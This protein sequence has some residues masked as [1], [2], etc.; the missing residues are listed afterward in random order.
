M[1]SNKAKKSKLSSK[2]LEPIRILPKLRKLQEDATFKFGESDNLKARPHQPFQASVQPE[3]HPS[4]ETEKTQKE[5]PESDLKT[6]T[7]NHASVEFISQ[8]QK[9][10]IC[11]DLLR[12]G[13][14]DS[15]H[16]FFA[17]IVAGEHLLRDKL[18]FVEKTLPEL[19]ELLMRAEDENSQGNFLQS[20][21]VYSDIAEKYVEAKVSVVARFF[22][23]RII[24]LLQDFQR[25]AKLESEVFFQ[26]FINAKL[27]LV[28]CYDLNT[29][30]AAALLILEEIYAKTN[31]NDDFKQQIALQLIQLY[32]KRGNEEERLGKYDSAVVFYQK[33]LSVCV[34]SGLQKEECSLVLIVANLYKKMG[35]ATR[36][37]ETIKIHHSKNV[38]LPRDFAVK[39]EISSLELLAKCFEKIHDLEEAENNY[40]NF[41]ELLRLN[42]EYKDAYA[43]KPSLKLGDIYWRKENY[44]EGLKYYLDYFEEGL[45]SKN[46]N[47]EII[48]K[49]RVTLSV[50]K[51]FDE[52]ESFMEYFQM[53]K[54]KVD[55]II[56]FKKH[57]RI[58]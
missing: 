30:S 14:L 15:F 36:A 31:S 51:G 2:K 28:K 48:N 27:G 18:V 21:S 38:K 5:E 22:Y 13:Y 56:I 50:A 3:T 9:H 40:K 4:K 32:Q 29:E 37:I 16:N 49:A 55:D 44:K 12:L 43:G 6:Q 52:F 47:R 46:K 8:N 25:E 19:K 24:Q 11:E 35:D 23:E 7:G 39:F 33:C 34:E 26:K 45:K 42:D 53:S 54:N 10:I 17:L 58:L 57:R 20:I 41:Y 1:D